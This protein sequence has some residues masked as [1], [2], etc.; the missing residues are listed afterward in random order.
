MQNWSILPEFAKK[1]PAKSAVFYRLF[2]GK[3]SPRNFPWKQLI[4]LRIC[5]WK[6]FEIWLFSTKIPQ[7][8]PIFLW[9]LTFLPRK[10]LEIDRFF[11]KFWL[12]FHEISWFFREFAPEN[13]TKFCF[14]FPRNIRSPVEGG[15][16]RGFTVYNLR[17]NNTR[18]FSAWH[19]QKNKNI[20]SGPEKQHSYNKKSIQI[21]NLLVYHSLCNFLK[22]LILFTV[23]IKDPVE[24]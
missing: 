17:K 4:F 18:K 15:L 20:Q 23:L 24:P 11:C 19:W 1:N 16:N 8:R 6:S 3:V 9:I 10:S 12:F 2:L 22:N 7:N 13:P 5:P 14:F 21:K